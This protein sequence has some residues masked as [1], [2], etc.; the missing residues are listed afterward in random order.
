M[1]GWGGG[2]RKYI[3]RRENTQAIEKLGKD[4]K[5][6]INTADCQLQFLLVLRVWV[7]RNGV[8]LRQ[9]NGRS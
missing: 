4:I 6:A 2:R 9:R 7:K 8:Y 3:S 1:D 5:T